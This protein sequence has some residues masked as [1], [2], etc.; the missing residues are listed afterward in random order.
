MQVYYIEVAATS[1][2][3]Y[4][5]PYNYPNSPQSPNYPNPAMVSAMPDDQQVLASALD[6]TNTD[7]YGYN[8]VMGCQFRLQLCP[9]SGS[10]LSLIH[11]NLYVNDA[12]AF[13]QFHYQ[14]GFHNQVAIEGE[15]GFS[16]EEGDQD[17]IFNL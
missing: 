8:Y 13:G 1:L 4:P 11:E 17:Y 2:F 10:T 12:G 7:P 5:Q 6:T 15:P 3:T 9:A 14:H 16:M